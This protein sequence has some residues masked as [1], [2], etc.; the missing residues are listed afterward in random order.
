M[1]IISLTKT[2]ARTLV[3]T[4]MLPML[5]L[6]ASDAEKLQKQLSQINSLHAAFEQKVVDVNNKV[7]QQG[8]GSFALS[9][10]NKLYWHLTQPDESV[11]VANKNGVWVFNPFAEEVTILDVKQAI[12]QSPM[13]LLIHRDANTW[14]Q[15]SVIANNDC[16]SIS[17]LNTEAPKTSVSA[18]FSHH[19]LTEF[20]IFDPQG[21]ISKFTL[22]QQRSLNKAESKL[23][24]FTVPDGVDI[25][26]QRS[27]IR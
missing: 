26:D 2:I 18:C 1:K 21:N 12:A 10:P 17:P 8:K 22:S 5:S 25:D 6:A 23:F 16:Y 14:S 15:Y 13:T 7:I 3:L 11:I 24:K 20:T 27:I 4:S 19:K 9:Y